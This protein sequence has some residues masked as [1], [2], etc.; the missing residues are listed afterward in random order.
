[1]NPAAQK[2]LSA[3]ASQ[4]RAAQLLLRQLYARVFRLDPGKKCRLS[5]VMPPRGDGVTS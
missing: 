1:L 4:S 5:P 2:A 3:R